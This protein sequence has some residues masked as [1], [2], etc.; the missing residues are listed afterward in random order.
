MLDL[1]GDLT[2]L[3]LEFVTSAVPS[4]FSSGGKR[5]AHERKNCLYPGR[6]EGAVHRQDPYFGRSARRRPRSDDGRLGEFVLLAELKVTNQFYEE[7]MHVA[8]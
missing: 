7:N 5:R 8:Q 1:P 2:D 3:L 6:H 4:S